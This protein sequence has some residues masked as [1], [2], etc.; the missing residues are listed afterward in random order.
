M[1]I[2]FLSLISHVFCFFLVENNKFHL[3]SI[4][5]SEAIVYTSQYYC[6]LFLNYCNYYY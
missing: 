1:L 5:Q 6:P 3:L 2:L 4:L